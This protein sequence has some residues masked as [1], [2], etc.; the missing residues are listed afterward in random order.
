MKE[1]SPMLFIE[2]RSEPDRVR[3]QYSVERNREMEDKKKMNKLNRR[4]KKMK[5]KK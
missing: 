5:S 1:K 4:L 3:V 2:V